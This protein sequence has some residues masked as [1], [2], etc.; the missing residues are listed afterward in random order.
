MSDLNQQLGV[1]NGPFLKLHSRMHAMLLGPDT[2]KLT[3]GAGTVP[4]ISGRKVV[5]MKKTV[6]EEKVIL[7]SQVLP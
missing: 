1:K 6:P 4:R 7:D 5:I 2:I 3:L